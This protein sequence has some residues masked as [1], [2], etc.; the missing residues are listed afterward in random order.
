MESVEQQAVETEVL[1]IDDSEC[2]G[3][4]WA[5]NRGIEEASHRYIAFLDADDLW[6]EKK[7]KR[8]LARLGETD[9]GIVVEGSELSSEYYL[10]ELF[11]GNI[12]SV[13]SSVM[14]DGNSV[15]VMFDEALERREDHLF[16]LKAASEA[17]I[18]F[19]QDLFTVRKHESGLS[20]TNTLWLRL[21]QDRKFA[22]RIRN[23]VPEIKLYLDDYYN[24]P[25]FNPPHHQNTLGDLLRLFFVRASIWTHIIM[26]VSIIGQNIRSEL[27]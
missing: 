19:S 18:S 23:Q 3:P 14:V 9:T 7:L 10:R 27:P 22:R 15:D 13:M 16:I 20:S 25:K 17:G 26:L 2:R 1:V 11:L 21:N 6:K 12:Q 8:Q 5:R 24:S 4:A